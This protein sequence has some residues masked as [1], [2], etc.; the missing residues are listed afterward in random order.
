MFRKLVLPILPLA[1]AL[2]CEPL[3]EARDVS[4]NFDLAY[5]DVLRI[6]L[7]DELIAEV[8]PGDDADITFDGQTFQLDAVCGDDGTDC[9]SETFWGRMA[10]EQPLGSGNKLLNFVNLD[11]ERGNPGDRIAGLMENDG[12]FAM[13]AGIGLDGNEACAVI[14]V[15]TVVGDFSGGNK[16][17]I[18]NATI[19]Y[20]WDAGCQIAGT[21]LT[22]SL[23]IETDVKGVRTGDLDLGELSTEPID[24]NG[25]PIEDEEPAR[26]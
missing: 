16:P 8:S 5:Q 3:D 20:E 2:G 14:G 25:E 17:D 18:D 13:L 19:V 11:Q 24:E 4:G 1:L 7:N 26:E 21:T 15:A 9:P 12:S 6:Y 10:V 23:R 22:G